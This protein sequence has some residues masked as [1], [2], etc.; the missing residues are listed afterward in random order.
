MAHNPHENFAKSNDKT[1][2]R[3][4]D[5]TVD[6]LFNCAYDVQSKVLSPTATAYKVEHQL[7]KELDF[8]KIDAKTGSLYASV[9]DNMNDPIKMKARQATDDKFFGSMAA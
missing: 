2:A 5:H 4:M 9:F 8:A 6:S 7:P 1:F 3:N